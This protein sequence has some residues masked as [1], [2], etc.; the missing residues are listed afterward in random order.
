MPG[1]G[2]LTINGSARMAEID[3]DFLLPT[4]VVAM[5]MYNLDDSIAP[6]LVP[7]SL[8][9]RTAAAGLCRPDTILRP[10]RPL[11]DIFQEVS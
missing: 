4:S 1:K 6:S 7:A 8:R 9:P 11:Q 10:M 2:K 5:G 3:H